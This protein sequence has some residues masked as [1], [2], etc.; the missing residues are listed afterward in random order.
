MTT[1]ASDTFRTVADI[2]DARGADAHLPEVQRR[3]ADHELWAGPVRRDRE[4][5]GSEDC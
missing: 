2:A 5:H 1:G 4:S 3:R